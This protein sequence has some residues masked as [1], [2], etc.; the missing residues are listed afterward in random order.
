MRVSPCPDHHPEV[1][2]A[3]DRFVHQRL[4]AAVWTRAG[5]AQL[6]VPRVTWVPHPSWTIGGN[7]TPKQLPLE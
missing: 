7:F 5:Y 2:R 1:D 6:Y 3:A 4:S